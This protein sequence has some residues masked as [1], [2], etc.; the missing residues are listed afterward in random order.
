[1]V[2]TALMILGDGHDQRQASMRAYRPCSFSLASASSHLLTVASSLQYLKICRRQATSLRRHHRALLSARV[3][4][5]SRDMPTRR[6]RP[7]PAS[8][9][10]LGPR[11][12]G[13]SV[14]L[15][16][17]K[18]LHCTIASCFMHAS[19]SHAQLLHASHS[20]ATTALK[21]MCPFFGPSFGVKRRVNW[22]VDG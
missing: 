22:V 15:M 1:M 12:Q 4:R 3:Q 8:A 20:T 9:R 14:S 19:L 18:T 17:R 10:H 5:A 6:G 11:N 13:S 21:I 7:A 2:M 16:R